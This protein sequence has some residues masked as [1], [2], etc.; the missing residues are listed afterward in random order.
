[1]SK[2]LISKLLILAFEVCATSR[3]QPIVTHISYC[4]IFPFSVHCA[5]CKLDV[6]T[7]FQNNLIL[8][9]LFI[10]FFVPGKYLHLWSRRSFV[11]YLTASLTRSIWDIQIYVKTM[12]VGILYR[13]NICTFVA[14]LCSLVQKSKR[15]ID[16][17]VYIYLS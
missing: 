8:R 14:H 11:N 12:Q 4:T 1:M 3:T 2:T 16:F 17:F 13:H 6:G 10:D 15:S 5:P 9:L 7:Y